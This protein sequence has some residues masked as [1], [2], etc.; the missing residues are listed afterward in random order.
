M[1]SRTNARVAV[2]A[3]LPLLLAACGPDSLTHDEL[4]AKGN[5]ICSDAQDIAQA[6]TS[7]RAAERLSVDFGLTEC[8]VT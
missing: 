5:Q 2:L 8:T 7:V 4:V 6:A 1:R 3:T